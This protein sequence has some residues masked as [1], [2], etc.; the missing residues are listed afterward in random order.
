MIDAGDQSNS[1]ST[2]GFVAW[3]Y[4]LKSELPF[5]AGKFLIK[6]TPRTLARKG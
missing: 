6:W 1:H 3:L 2:I 4:S 5:S